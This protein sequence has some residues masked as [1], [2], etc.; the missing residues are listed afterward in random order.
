V[1]Q[2]SAAVLFGVGKGGK[3]GGR[4]KDK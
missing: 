2:V 4:E 3:E 1:V